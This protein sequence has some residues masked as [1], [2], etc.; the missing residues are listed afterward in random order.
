[1]S[2]YFN[3]KIYNQINLPEDTFPTI[4]FAMNPSG[5]GAGSQPFS[6]NDK[7]RKLS[8]IFN[9]DQVELMV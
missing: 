4:E 8:H 3:E 6:T 5:H 2:H 9:K 7:I 1:M